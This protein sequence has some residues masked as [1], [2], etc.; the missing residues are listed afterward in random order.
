[1]KHRMMRHDLTPTDQLFLYLEHCI[2]ECEWIEF[3]DE[4]LAYL[5]RNRE[6]M[7]LMHAFASAYSIPLWDKDGTALWVIWAE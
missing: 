2:I 7:A 5:I 6:N 1:M 4:A 3:K